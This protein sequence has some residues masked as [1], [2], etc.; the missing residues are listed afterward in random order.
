[1]ISVQLMA[2]HR[3]RSYLVAVLSGTAGVFG[4]SVAYMFFGM[5]T[6]V[7]AMCS[8]WAPQWWVH[9]YCGFAIVVP[10]FGVWFAVHSR[11]RYLRVQAQGATAK[12]RANAVE[13]H[14]IQE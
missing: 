6:G 10:M 1:M 8:G 9:V 3:K 7:I 4:A 2:T 12:F 5:V 14:H 13:V 11:R